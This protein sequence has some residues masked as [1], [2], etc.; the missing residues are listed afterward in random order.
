[1]ITPKLIEKKIY[2]IRNTKVMLDSDLS[3][4]YGVETKYLNRQVKRNLE[5]LSCG[6]YVSIK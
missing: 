1:M 2:I 5:R 3:K 4:L 6:V